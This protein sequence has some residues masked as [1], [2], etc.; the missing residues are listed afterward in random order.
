MG[1]N[2]VGWEANNATGPLLYREVPESQLVSVRAKISSQTQGNWS[3]AGVMA[4]VPNQG[5]GENWQISWSFRPAGGFQHQSNQSLNGVEAELNDAGLAAANL[6]YVRLDNMGG[7]VFQAYRGSGPDDNSIT[8]TPQMDANMMPQP[9]TNAN[10]VGQT[11]QV[12]PAAGAIGMLADANVLFDW[13]EIQTTSQTFRDDFT[14]TR[15][16]GTDGVLPGGIWTGIVNGTSG[17][18]NTRVGASVGRCLVCNWDDDDSG[19]FNVVNN[20]TGDSPGLAFPPNGNDTTVVFGAP[21]DNPTATIFSDTNVTIKE[22]RFDTPNI[23]ALSGPGSITLEADTGSALINVLQGNH[24]I[25]IDLVLNDNVTATA[26]A[27]TSLNIN[28]PI[29]LNGNTFTISAGST[30]NLNDGTMLAGSGSAAGQVANGGVLRGLAGVGGDFSQSPTGSLSVTAG[31]A[32]IQISGSADLGGV[33]EVSLADGFVPTPG[34]Q[35]TVLTAQS[36]IDRGLVLGGED[37]G[38]FHL[39]VGDGSVSLVAGAIP[40]PSAVALAAMALAI[41]G[42]ARRRRR[43]AA[44]ASAPSASRRMRQACWCAVFFSA[45]TASSAWAQE[46]IETRRDD[47]GDPTMPHAMQH[48][49]TTGTVPVGKMWNGIHNPTNGG[50]E[51]VPALFVADGFAFDGTDKAGKLHIEDLGLHVNSNA[52]LGTGWEPQGDKNNSAFLFTTFSGEAA[53]QYDFDA[54]MKIDAQTAGNWSYAAIIARVAGPPVGICCGQD[55]ANSF[56]TTGPDAENHITAG[57]FRTD[58]ANPD[59]ATLLVQNTL[60]GGGGMP[61]EFIVDL[62]PAGA[63]GGGA[64]TPTY[65]RLQ[66]RG[67]QFSADSSLDGTTWFDDP[68]TNNSTVNGELNVPGRTLEVG[69]A[70]MGFPGGVANL[71]DVDFFQL[72]LY[73]SPIPTLAK[74]NAAGSGN[75]NTANNWMSVPAGTVPNFDTMAVEFNETITGPSTVFNDQAAVAKSLKFQNT[76]KYAIAGTG[77][78]TMRSDTGTST[79]NVDQGSHEIQLDLALANP[80]TVTAAAGA[81][82][83]INNTLD[84][85]NATPASRTMT[86]A[87]AGRVNI[88]NNIDLPVTG[89][90][91]TVNGGHVGGNGRI[92]GRLTNTG[93]QVSPGID[94]GT[95]TVEGNFQQNAAG[96]LNIDLGGLAVG[97]YDRLA[98]VGGLNGAILDGTLDVSYLNNFLPSVGNTFDVLTAAGGIN[99]AGVISLHPSDSPF[100]SL[101]VVSGTIL[102]LTLTTPLPP[103][104]DDGDFNGDGK[105]DAADYVVWRK[106]DGTPAGYNEWR[107]NFG[108]TGGS[109]SSVA[110]AAAVPEPASC[111]I[112][113]VSM[114]TVLGIV[115]RRG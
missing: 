31:G 15:D 21:L 69:I 34:A 108:R 52:T 95:L 106:S 67:A 11:L 103:P 43:A 30:V 73:R 63:V 45:V 101:A 71:V 13:V 68:A 113:L 57:V 40:E 53:A 64:T 75:W 115:R 105:V 33:L 91:V 54:V 59:N 36:V 76:N 12:G 84:F 81:R 3:Q 56:A 20:W 82:L 35:Y 22:V 2:N 10:L 100:Y 110:E 32:P 47:F 94:V 80:T 39:S 109:G 89:A 29:I 60:N 49:Y 61:G 85:T 19:N 18:F 97:Q 86:V 27:G 77:S 72:D 92:N 78:L 74:W 58:A 41:G 50:S 25:Q 23:V 48:D 1:M 24:E 87:G 102:R 4:R 66:K 9:Q 6:M 37:G 111:A 99:N 51:T 42:L 14:Y 7:G 26:A 112:L 104:T 93:G 83:D 70:V 62:A 55:A 107:T 8:W 38:L 16:L 114:M 98:V 90:V 88:N 28:T 65:V 17:G 46:L 44:F 96:T 5:A 79:I